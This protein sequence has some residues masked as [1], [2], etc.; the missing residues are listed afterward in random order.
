M[1]LGGGYYFMTHH[2]APS[3]ET[4][5]QSAQGETATAKNDSQAAGKFNGSFVDLSARSGSWKCT[6]DSSTAGSISSGTT[7]VSDGKV[8][9]DFTTNV[10]GY[11][12]VESHMFSDGEFAYTWSSMMPQGIKTKVTAQSTAGTQTSGQGVNA[13]TSYSYDC[14]PWVVNQALLTVP[15]S[16]TFKSY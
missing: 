8:R 9:A 3:A 4:T 7:Y 14:Q 13:N 12:S 11:G 10:Q 15:T 2:S 5:T 1:V 6:V 16:V